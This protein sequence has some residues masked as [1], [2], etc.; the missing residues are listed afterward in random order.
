ME[1]RIADHYDSVQC[2]LKA[3]PLRVMLKG[4]Q[5]FWIIL[6]CLGTRLPAQQDWSW[7][8]G[9]SV[10]MRFPNGGPPVVDSLAR[11]RWAFESMACIS[12]SSGNLLY[13]TDQNF[14]YRSN[15]SKP[16]G[17]TNLYST[18]MSNGLQFLPVWGGDA[19]MLFYLCAG[20][21]NSLSLCPRF[22]VLDIID[23]RDTVRLNLE[24]GY[25]HF[26]Y[27]PSE[28]IAAV[29]DA[30]GTGWWVVGHGL[31]DNNIFKYKVNGKKVSPIVLQSI[32]SAY[33]VV[34]N[35]S[36][37]GQGELCFSPQGDKLLMV[38][39]SGIVDV[40]DFD[41]C[42]GMLSNWDSLG[43]PALT[44][45]GPDIYYGC[46]FSPDGTK[47]Y[48]AEATE[49]PDINHLWQWD[50]NA[51]DIRASKT[52]IFTL[53][54]STT[55]G[56]LQLGPDG[57]VYAAMYDYYDSLNPA[58]YY[59][60]VINNPNQAG[61]A[62]NFSYL[63][64]WLKGLRGTGG[65]PN[66]PNYNL[67]PLVRQVAEAGPA[68][69]ICPPMVGMAHDS[70]R[71]GYPD[72]TGGAVVYH[73]LPSIGVRDTATAYTWASPDTSTWYYLTAFD[74][75]MGMPCG[76]TV[77]SVWVE[78]VDSSQLTVYSLGADT[79][80]CLGDTV[81]LGGATHPGWLYA[82]STGDTTSS[83]SV[84]AGGSYSVTVTNPVA[85]LHCLV[86]SDTIMIT[87]FPIPQPLQL[88][89]A[90]ADTIVC[91]GDSVLIGSHSV[92]GWNYVWSPGS[93]LNSTTVSQPIAFPI[94]SEQYTV[95]ASDS[96]SGGVC[97]SISDSV[98][99]V[100]EQPFA[101]AAPEDVSF[102]VGECFTVG[103]PGVNG[104]QYSWLP[105]T[106]LSS[107]NLS[108]TKAQP[109]ATTLYNLTVTNPNVQ[110]VNCRERIFPVLATADACNHQSFIA[111]NG[112][113]V[114]ELLDFGNHAGVVSMDVFDAAGRKVFASADYL[115][116]FDAASLAKGLYVY[117]VNVV[118]DCPSSFVGKILVLR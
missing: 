17:G 63:S 38:T 78:V 25:Y 35:N 49:A 64:L 7:V 32:G 103:V 73:W 58:R 44:Y 65:L 33:V 22:S 31:L 77:D 37:A 3:R 8:F 95:A 23:T 36:S 104:L 2:R 16:P 106:G 86:D 98:S 54:D 88:G 117:R 60:S 18:Y 59:L 68:R 112:N 10:L 110:S 102:C 21:C 69:K 14:I 47:I 90:G 71:I 43:T 96:A 41:R 19:Y 72:S 6:L 11:T 39:G 42:T 114:A 13:Y 27:G 61:T 91:V 12:D 93:S 15:G 76:L 1:G 29:R 80:V 115:N 67:S 118:G 82:W 108:F 74:T 48:V 107:P 57:K 30:Q 94:V 89:F 4:I 20:L 83:V 9:D 100:V 56:A 105:I 40:F 85:N 46:A 53:P 111:V 26:L 109:T 52:L 84:S 99:V 66:L 5:I 101:H 45:P 81:Q 62:C 50:L 55:F 79:V 97:V 75:A 113:G 28:K 116:D 51:P 24:L 34:G 92:S 87:N 70:V